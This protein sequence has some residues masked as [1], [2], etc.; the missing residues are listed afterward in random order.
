MVTV[1]RAFGCRFVIFSN[2]H[3]PAHIHVVGAGCEA[4]VQLN[5]EMG[6]TLVWHV[7]FKPA[8]MRRIM[9]E[10]LKERATLLAKWD[11]IHG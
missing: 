8:D 1:H 5:G 7:G 3:E 10:V 4:K 6:L 11:E 9:A 2:D